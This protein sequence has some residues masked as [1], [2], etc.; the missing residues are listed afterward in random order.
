VVGAIGTA[1]VE[2]P[3]IGY[4]PEAARLREFASGTVPAREFRA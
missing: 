1:Q 3:G 2:R 4:A